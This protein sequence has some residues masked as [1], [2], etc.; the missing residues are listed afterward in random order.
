MV[1]VSRCAPS[2]TKGDLDLF[3]VPLCW[4]IQRR[5]EFRKRLESAFVAMKALSILC[6]MLALTPKLG[7]AQEIGRAHV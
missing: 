6:W 7:Q 1:V 3:T 4:D 2:Q 5:N